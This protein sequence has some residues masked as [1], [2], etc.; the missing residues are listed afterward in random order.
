[1]LAFC[2]YVFSCYK[3]IVQFLEVNLFPT[4][5][6]HISIWIW[7]TSRTRSMFYWKLFRICFFHSPLFMPLIV[8]HISMLLHLNVYVHAYM[9]VCVHKCIFT[10]AHTHVC[11]HRYICIVC[12]CVLEH[13]FLGTHAYMYMSVS[14]SVRH[15][16]FTYIA[17][18]DKCFSLSES[19]T[20]LLTSWW[21]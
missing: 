1:M 12:V 3:T 7:H 18:W 14:F 2:V 9:H 19:Q 11:V 6:Y 13:V 15:Y 17:C 20:R 21:G 10:Y 4:G 16:P 8:E 5:Y